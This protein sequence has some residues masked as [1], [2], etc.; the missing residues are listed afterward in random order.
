V[1][2]LREAV[3]EIRDFFAGN[4][5]Y[6]G[7]ALAFAV[8]MWVWV[9]S[10]QVVEERARVRLDW[11]LPDGLMLVEPPL[12]TATVTVEGVQAFVR[13]VRQKDLSILLDLSRAREGE[14]SLD[15]SERPVAGMASQ[16]R[17][18]SVSPS[19]LKVQL[20]R[21]LERRVNVV[22]VIQGEP[23]DGFRVGKVVVKPER[24][25]LSG[26]SSVLRGLSEIAADAVDIS[27]LKEDAVFQ[28][29][30][31]TQ[32]GQLVPTVPAR[33]SVEVKIEPIVK[34][35]AFEGV[36][37][38]LRDGER[39]LTGAQSVKVTLAG[40]VDRLNAIDPEEV[41][42]L[43]HVPDGWNGNAGEARRGRGEGLRYEVV[44]PAGEVVSVVGV[45]PERIPVERR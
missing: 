43:V 26:P 8:M 9:Q 3:V 16:V 10:E 45:T 23:A 17:V 4:L 14:V 27:G 30:L 29:G 35:R 1:S 34:E 44:Q 22:A 24:V 36:P 11:K 5:A 39:F 28:V 7:L 19:T 2:R 13:T 25:A 15:L 37:V 21:V 32:A 31:A 42:V 33:F 38:L 12:E 41:S 20:D 40:P 6:K 18:V